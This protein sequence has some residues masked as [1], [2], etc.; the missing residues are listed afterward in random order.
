MGAPVLPD[1]LAPGL[2][3]VF[4]GTAPG[5]ASAARGHYYAGPGN[6]FWTFLHDAGIVP[7]PL[8]PEDDARV[9]AHGIGLT[10]LVKSMAQSHDRGLP[11]DVPALAAKVAAHRPAWIAFTSKEAGTQAARWLGR[12]RPGLGAQDWTFENARVFVLPSPSGRNQGRAAYDGRTTR[13]EWW[14]E[15]GRLLG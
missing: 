5:L 7:E 13:L 6:R 4:C 14:S 12:P 2:R 10:D 9:L 3:A 11:Y 15:L 1:L 8:G